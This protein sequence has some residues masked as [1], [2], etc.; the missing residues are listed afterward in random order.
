MKNSDWITESFNVTGLPVTAVYHQEDVQKIFLP[1]LGLWTE[2]QKMLG[3]RMFIFMAAPP[4]CGKSTLA[5]YLEKLSRMETLTPVQAA[6]MDGFHHT[7]AYLK[8]HRTVRDG[9]TI[10]LDEIK[11]A[12]ETYDTEKF[13]AKLREASENEELR[14]PAYSRTEHDVLEDVLGISAKIVI[15]EGNYLLL[16]RSPWKEITEEYCDFGMYL[17]ADQEVLKKRLVGRKAA[18]GHSQADAESFYEF[19]DGRNAALVLNDRPETDLV[20]ECREGRFYRKAGCREE[21]VTEENAV[22]ENAT[23]RQP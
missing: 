7:A 1:L 11:G 2:R 8:S 10:L 6:A 13:A 12:P 23:G 9:R 19:S 21:K 5:A 20:L 3:R 18:S 22:K 17:Y 16:D 4:G 15:V 14:W